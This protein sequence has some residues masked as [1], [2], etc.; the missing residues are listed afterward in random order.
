MK[1]STISSS[2]D[3]W[4]TRS[5]ISTSSSRARSAGDDAIDSLSQIGHLRRVARAWT[6]SASERGE[7]ARTATTTASDATI[8]PTAATFLTRSDTGGLR[9]DFGAPAS[10]PSDKRQGTSADDHQT[11]QPQQPHQR[12]PVGIDG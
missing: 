2:V 10:T 6:R 1:K 4:A 3:P 11:A 7:E 5:S 8:T 12:E 9:D